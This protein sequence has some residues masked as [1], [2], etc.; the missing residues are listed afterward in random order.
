MT[1]VIILNININFTGLKYILIFNDY[2]MVILITQKYCH[3]YAC[4]RMLHFTV[5]WQNIIYSPCHKHNVQTVTYLTWFNVGGGE[6]K[7]ETKNYYQRMKPLSRYKYL[8]VHRAIDFINKKKRVIVILAF[9]NISV[10][11]WQYITNYCIYTN[12]LIEPRD[13]KNQ[14]I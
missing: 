13:E 8:N 7:S 6:Q 5:F 9:L 10:L 4:V 11:V 3:Y 2:S 1:Q 12:K 14:K